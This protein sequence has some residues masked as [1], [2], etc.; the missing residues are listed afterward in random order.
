MCI[1][2][3]EIKF[4]VIIFIKFYFKVNICGEIVCF[5]CKRGFDGCG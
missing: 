5:W 2:Y 4:G 3:L 1:Y